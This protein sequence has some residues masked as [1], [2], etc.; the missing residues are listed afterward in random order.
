MTGALAMWVVRSSD[1]GGHMV[2]KTVQEASCIR[3]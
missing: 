1:T 3:R 2:G